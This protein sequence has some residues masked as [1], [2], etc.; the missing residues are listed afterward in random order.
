MSEE[1]IDDQVNKM[2]DILAKDEE[3]KEIPPK[4]ESAPE[5]VSEEEQKPSDDAKPEDQAPDP[6][7][8]PPS[9]PSDEKEA[10]Q[11]LP[12]WAQETISRREREREAAFTQRSMDIANRTRQSAETER[13]ANE[14]RARYASELEK[15]GQMAS[16][17]MPAKFQDIQT[18]ADYIKLKQSDPGRASE[19]EAFQMMLRN[20]QAQS[21]QVQQQQ[22]TEHL[23]REW[24]MLQEKLPEVKDPAKA[25]PLMD[26]VRKAAIEYYGYSPDEAAVIGDHRYVLILKDAMAWRDQQANLKTAAAK[27]AAPAPQRVIKPGAASSAKP[28]DEKRAAL[29]K[30]A[31]YSENPRDQAEMLSALLN[32]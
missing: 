20:A 19:F 5:T 17:L 22:R 10:F 25:K 26:G 6:I 18:E 21:Q 2:E 3:D 7:E 23:D 28:S 27:K 13:V 31:R 12:T 32:S 1:N 8:A 4:G 9:W 16:Q 24:T 11:S 29:L 14:T 30:R 15:L